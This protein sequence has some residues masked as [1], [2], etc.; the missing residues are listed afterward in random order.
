MKAEFGAENVFDFSLGNPDVPPPPEFDA[1]IGKLLADHTP[2]AHGYMPNGGY[3]WVREALA[4]RMSKEQ[5]GQ[6]TRDEILMTCGAAGALNVVMKA[7]LD[8]GD[9]VALQIV[10]GE[11]AAVDE[12]RGGAGQPERPRL[13]LAAAHALVRELRA[14]GGCRLAFELA[15]PPDLP[16]GRYELR[17]TTEDAVEE[18]QVLCLIES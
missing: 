2:G 10:R 8:P 1:A 16:Q 4:G 3:P 13:P 18:D 17:L 15:L 7:L 5:G 9:E 11:R 14:D 12:D 6:L